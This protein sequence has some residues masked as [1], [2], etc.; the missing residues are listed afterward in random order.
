MAHDGAVSG[1]LTVF[2]LN[3]KFL[4]GYSCGLTFGVCLYIIISHNMKRVF[5]LV[6]IFIFAI[7]NTR[8]LLAGPMDG[9][10]HTTDSSCGGVNVNIYASKSDVYLE[11]G[12]KNPGS[13]G[14]D[15]GEYYVQVTEPNGTLLGT[16]LGTGDDTPLVV[17]NGEFVSCY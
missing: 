9:A 3:L 5:I 15:D 2:C 11:G 17:L 12:P 6:F 10:I 8:V 1:I 13:A 7:L 14:L 4:Y 16:S